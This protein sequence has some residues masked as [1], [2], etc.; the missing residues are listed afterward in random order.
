MRLY[1]GPVLTGVVAGFV[2]GSVLGLF[3]TG[4]TSDGSGQDVLLVLLSFLTEFGAGFV[5]GRFS[6]DSQAL[7]GS[8][9]AL[10]LYL[11]ASII[12]LTSGANLIVLI[13]GAALALAIGTMGGVLAMAVDKD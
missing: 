4:F 1:W 3:I 9:S 8:Q 12:A 10:A 13:I 11:V 2:I 6:P 5:A 7:N